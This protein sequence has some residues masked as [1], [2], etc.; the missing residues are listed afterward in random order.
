[1]GVSSRPSPHG[2]EDPWEGPSEVVADGAD[3]EPGHPHVTFL[4]GG[5]E[6]AI[7]VARLREIAP[8]HALTRVPGVPE[9]VRGVMNLRGTV[10][11]IL[12]LSARF[13]L[14]TTQPSKRACILV[15]DLGVS[16]A[17]VRVGLLVDSVRRVLDV[18]ATEISPS[19]AF[20]LVMAPEY[21]VG[22]VKAEAGRFVVLVDVDHVFSSWELARLLDDPR[23]AAPSVSVRPTT[24]SAT[25][26]S[27]A[28]SSS[29][30]QP[31]EGEPA[32]GTIVLFDDEP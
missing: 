3:Q 1:M 6:H 18:R 24:M 15:V 28:V 13:G 17:G 23:L 4:L 16:D 27:T 30:P 2:R 10:L 21:V 26:G 19:P 14:A 12:D 7:E 29:P 25:L 22:L 11:P 8:L 31:P 9:W 32:A 5:H 20:G